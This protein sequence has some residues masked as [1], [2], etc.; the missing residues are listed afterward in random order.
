MSRS[1]SLVLTVEIIAGTSDENAAVELQMLSTDMGVMVEAMQ[2][3]V[4]MRAFPGQ[5]WQETLKDFQRHERL[6][7]YPKS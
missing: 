3:D 5:D 2:R 1:S 7:N 4:K 6:S